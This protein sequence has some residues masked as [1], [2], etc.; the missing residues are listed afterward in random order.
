[1]TCDMCEVMFAGCAVVVVTGHLP[2][3]MVTYINCPVVNG[4]QIFSSCGHLLQSTYGLNS[5]ELLAL[6]VVQ[7]FDCFDFT[8]VLS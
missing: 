3:G 4:L 1:M 6:Y 2:V 8:P 5:R 7:C